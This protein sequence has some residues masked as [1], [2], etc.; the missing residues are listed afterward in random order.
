MEKEVIGN[1]S[2]KVDFVDDGEEKV[3]GDAALDSLWQCILS[4]SLLQ[5]LGSETKA[6]V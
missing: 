1:S 5:S 2:E 4:F 3:V 6:D